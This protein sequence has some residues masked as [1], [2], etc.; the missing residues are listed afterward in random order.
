[1]KQSCW[2]RNWEVEGG[3]DRP[4]GKRNE[5]KRRNH[6]RK[7]W[8]QKKVKYLNRYRK[9]S[10]KPNGGIGGEW[11][12]KTELNDRG[13]QTEGDMITKIGAET[14]RERHERA[15]DPLM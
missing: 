13:M 5:A 1:M 8:K 3:R 2:E 11:R 15:R 14:C 9:I 4:A 10:G 6:W 12:R 7:S